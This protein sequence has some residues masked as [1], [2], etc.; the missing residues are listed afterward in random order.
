L[1]VLGWGEMKRIVPPSEPAQHFDAFEIEDHRIGVA[2]AIAERSDLDR[3]VV[4]IDAGGG[5]AGGRVDAADRDVGGRVG[6]L[7]HDARR[8]PDHVGE[9]AD[10]AAVELLLREGA[11]AQRNLAQRF[12]LAG[13]GDDDVAAILF[14]LDGLFGLGDCDGGKHQRRKRDR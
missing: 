7:E 10:A 8:L 13:R 4:D 3:R 5:G 12:R 11:D 1:V 2:T 14:R 9:V 6:R